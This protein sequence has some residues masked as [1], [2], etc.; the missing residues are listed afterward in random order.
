MNKTKDEVRAYFDERPKLKEMINK[1]KYPLSIDDMSTDAIINTMG[2]LDSYDFPGEIIPG[3]KKQKEI[4]C[5]KKWIIGDKKDE[6]I[7]GYKGF[8]R[9]LSCLGFQYKVGKEYENTKTIWACENGFHAC[10]FPLDVLRYYGGFTD[11]Y[12]IVEQWGFID[13]RDKK[14]A[15]SNIKIVKEISLRELFEAAEKRLKPI[16]DSNMSV[17]GEGEICRNV[18]LSEG[19]AI[20]GIRSNIIFHRC[21]QD[22]GIVE[23]KTI[24]G[25]NNIIGILGDR[26]TINVIGDRN[27]IYVFGS[28]IKIN[29]TG[30]INSVE[31]NE[32][33]DCNVIATNVIVTGTYNVVH[34]NSTAN[35]T[36]IGE[37]NTIYVG[38]SGVGS[39]I[40]FING[41]SNFPIIAEEENEKIKIK[42]DQILRVKL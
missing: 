39:H 34:M 7:V 29:V 17:I 20:E 19:L 18:S 13:E 10:Q 1:F 38:I 30:D 32:G 26:F 5:F 14:R 9:D 31:I 4:E 23:N 28:E 27:L 21:F 11:R 35:V 36:C 16:N 37:E 41:T 24:I 6:H 3:L 2:L 15:S 33:K 8:K 12:C 42:C 40:N 22:D 25:D